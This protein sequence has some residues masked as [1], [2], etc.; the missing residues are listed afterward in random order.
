MPVQPGKKP[1]LPRR[2]K[3]RFFLNPYQDLVFTKCPKCDTKTKPRKIPLV[4][5]IEP[6]QLF[7]LN[8]TCRFCPYCELII[9]KQAELESLMS[10]YFEKQNPALVGNKYLV[11]GTVEKREWKEGNKGQLT[12]NTLLKQ[13]CIFRDVWNFDVKPA[14]WYPSS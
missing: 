5:H 12:P 13:A 4:I 6:R 2:K 8:K 10:A 9:A 1:A 14:G 3:Y 11:F 7:V